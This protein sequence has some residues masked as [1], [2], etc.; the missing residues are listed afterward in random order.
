MRR[1]RCPRH[2]RRPRCIVAGVGAALLF[3]AAGLV[4]CAAPAL[5]EDFIASAGG[6]DASGPSDPGMPLPAGSELIHFSDRAE[7]RSPDEPVPTIAPDGRPPG[8]LVPRI[9]ERGRL[10]VG[11]DQSQNRLSFRNPVSGRLEGFEVALGREIARDIF[12]DPNAVD[13]R[14]I[15]SDDLA[16]VLNDGQVDV[17][18]RAMTITPERA[19]SVTF[20]APYLTATKRLLLPT[21]SAIRGYQDLT[22]H[23]V[24]VAAGSTSLDVLP[25]LVDEVTVLTVRRWSDC[26]LALQ[27][28]QV[29]AIFGDDAILS[30]IADQDLFTEMAGTPATTEHYGAI[31][32]LATT[33]ER[34]NLVRQVNATLERIRTD[35]T[36]EKLYNR[37]F[38]D[39]L[40]Y[41]HPPAPVYAREP[42]TPADPGEEVDTP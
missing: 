42:A 21:D 3:G 19:E 4:G 25:A 13:F 26:L 40:T 32:P 27:Q 20:S 39:A 36:W 7:H 18:L 38:D 5:D 29:D 31:M 16:G 33:P 22:H 34:Q 1:P 8:E 17:I 24:C 10:I 11:I 37:W 2:P 6:I 9:V 14:F 30:G 41:Y 35:G 15:H 28:G 12:G 23:R